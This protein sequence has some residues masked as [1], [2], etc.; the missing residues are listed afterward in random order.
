MAGTWISY[1]NML[2]KV[3]K[4]TLPTRSNKQKEKKSMTKKVCGVDVH[5]DLLVATILDTQT[6]IKQTMHYRNSLDNI[7]Q[8]VNWLKQQNCNQAVMES[9]SI[10]WIPLYDAL[11]AVKFQVTLANA[12]Q[13][14]AIPGRK[15]DQTDS[16][17]ASTP[18]KCRFNQTKLC[19]TK[20]VA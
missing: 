19:A 16:R 6:Q 12:Y 14:K 9:T 5:R 4:N 15:T 1:R 13:V 17:V 2:L 8:L 10:Y 18:T 7:D 11:E 20:T 3:K